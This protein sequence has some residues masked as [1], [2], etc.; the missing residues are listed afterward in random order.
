M[1]N[2]AS[3][4]LHPNWPRVVHIVP[5]NVTRGHVVTYVFCGLQFLVC[6]LVEYRHPPSNFLRM[7]RAGFVDRADQEPNHMNYNRKREYKR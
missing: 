6:V 1:P 3:E 5:Q 4:V 2:F 7:G